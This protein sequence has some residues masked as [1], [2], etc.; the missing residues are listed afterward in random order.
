MES[1]CMESERSKLPIPLRCL[2]VSFNFTLVFQSLDLHSLSSDFPI[3]SHSLVF[4]EQLNP[5][6]SAITEQ[7]TCN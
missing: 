4:P 3:G 2:S 1:L 6:Y 7:L 5:F